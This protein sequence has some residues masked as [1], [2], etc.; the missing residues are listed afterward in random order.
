MGADTGTPTPTQTPATLAVPL[1]PRPAGC[2]RCRS[3][4]ARIS[5][6]PRAAAPTAP[7][8]RASPGALA[9]PGHLQPPVQ[10]QKRRAGAE[11]EQLTG[12]LDVAD[13]PR[14]A[15]LC[16]GSSPKAWEWLASREQPAPQERPGPSRLRGKLAATVTGAVETQPS[17]PH[18]QPRASVTPPRSG[19]AA[20][21][22]E[23]TMGG[24]AQESPEDCRF[25]DVSSWLAS[26]T[27]VRHA[28]V[29][30]PP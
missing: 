19:L 28:C 7:E 24:P 9:Q 6:P 29:P 5:R 15:E 2:P 18:V 10:G 14:T 13:R 11:L 27:S 26:V 17:P 23:E 1:S 20:A 8:L 16:V 22:T 12:T 4:P 3:P 21:R 25:L 30:V